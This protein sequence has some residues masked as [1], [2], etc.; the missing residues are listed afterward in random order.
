MGW[1]YRVAGVVF[2]A[3]LI[4]RH[5][6]TTRISLLLRPAGTQGPQIMSAFE[7]FLK[8][9]P[10]WPISLTAQR[11]R[12]HLRR[13]SRAAGKEPRSTPRQPQDDIGVALAR[14]EKRPQQTGHT[15]WQCE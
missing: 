3:V 9:I 14:T 15:V 8:T 6:P 4:A 1:L 13:H 12:K 11:S 2:I 10:R 7:K 5:V